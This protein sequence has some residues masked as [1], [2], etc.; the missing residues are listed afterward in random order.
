[1]STLVQGEPVCV[2]SYM[3][4]PVSVYVFPFQMYCSQA[5]ASNVELS[6]WEML[7]YNVSVLGHPSVLV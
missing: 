3:Y 5:V 1:M 2:W 4:V 7:R 6:C